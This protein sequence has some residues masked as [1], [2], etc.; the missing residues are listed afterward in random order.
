MRCRQRDLQ[1]DKT[2]CVSMRAGVSLLSERS[3]V[4]FPNGDLKEP[5][6]QERSSWLTESLVI[7]HQ[8]CFPPFKV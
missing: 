2:L 4:S 1:P 5:L 8:R 6:E 3:E 7:F